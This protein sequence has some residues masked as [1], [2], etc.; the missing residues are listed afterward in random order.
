MPFTAFDNLTDKNTIE[1]TG[2]RQTAWC[3]ICEEE[4][5][6]VMP[7]DPDSP[8]ITPHWRHHK[9]A[10]CDAGGEM[11][12]WHRAWQGR[13]PIENREVR[14]GE[15]GK[16]HFADV[17]IS[18]LTIEFQ[19][20]ML[21]F[22]ERRKRQA[23]YGNMVWVLHIP[24]MKVECRD[25]YLHGWFPEREGWTRD[26]P[27]WKTA[28]RVSP[29]GSEGYVELMVPGGTV[30]PVFIDIE[31]GFL[32]EIIGVNDDSSLLRFVAIDAFVDSVSRGE[33]P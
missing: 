12:P 1:P 10:D 8:A 15:K 32:L 27:R 30:C 9:A 28:S 13:F 33:L 20:S 16:G 31:M 11:S 24:N 22:P 14:I 29:D 25:G 23:F 6:S 19:H 3:K 2:K 4:T 17:H 5:F 18:G 7:G 26:L 21:S